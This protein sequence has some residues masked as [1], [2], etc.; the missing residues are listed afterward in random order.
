MGNVD[1]IHFGTGEDQDS[2]IFDILDPA[3]ACVVNEPEARWHFAAIE[4]KH[5]GGLNIW[6]ASPALKPAQSGWDAHAFSRAIFES[7][8]FHFARTGQYPAHILLLNELNLDYERGEETGDGGAF[9]TNPD[10]WPALYSKLAD[11][12]D[13]LLYACRERAHDRGF[14]P[15]FW[16]Q[17]WAP[18][19]G[20]TTPEIA[21]IWTPVARKYDGI[22]LHS[23]HDA[24]TITG[25]ILW[26][27]TTFPDHVLCLGEW[28]T[29]NYQGDRHQEEIRIR[30]RLQ[31]LERARISLYACYF[32]YAWANDA[33]HEHDIQ[34]NDLRR[35]L[36]DGRVEIPVDPFVPAINVTPDPEPPVIP[37]P[38]PEEPTVPVISTLPAGVD[39]ASYQ[40]YPDWSQVAGAG[41]KFGITKATEG[42]NYINPTLD[43]NW[44][45]IKNAGMYRFAYHFAR[46]DLNSA[47]NEAGFFFGV[48]ASRGIQTGDGLALDLESINGSLERAED[49]G[50]SVAMW[51][52][53]FMKH[54]EAMC[55]F[56]PLLYVSKSVI[57]QFDLGAIPEL[58][59]YGL[60]LASW[61]SQFPTPV[62]PWEVV[63]FWQATDDWSV[64]GIGGPVDGDYFNGPEAAIP[65]YGYQP[66]VA[67]PPVVNPPVNPDIPPSDDAAALQAR[68]AELTQQNDDLRRILG[69]STHDI[70]DALQKEA[71]G[72]QGSV[73]ALGAAIAQ[74]RR[75][76]P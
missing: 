18:G 45:N 46:P 42:V 60:W 3:G 72:I 52:L 34:G 5:P 56:K 10:N 30:S 25:D 74:L 76:S 39:V 17:G 71:D 50:T 35:S 62:Y 11:F 38:E 26:Y 49:K 15:W 23:Y 48:M 75:Q 54:L 19:H 69:Y 16:F 6:R 2:G 66:D 41:Y 73:N 67:K 58:G 20:E 22:V 68:L 40:G 55:G 29:Y 53:G 24:D 47:V 13:A 70:A 57:D 36:W 44:N 37:D 12:L 31:A 65:L 8:D 63:A 33:K 14:Y 27:R 51:T 43:H 61:S 28:N 1:G 59:E 9:D 32:I 21:N 64:P 4:R 7:I